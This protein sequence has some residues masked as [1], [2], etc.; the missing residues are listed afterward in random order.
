PRVDRLYPVPRALLLE[1]II[2]GRVLFSGLDLVR[3][4][5]AWATSIKAA[6]SEGKVPNA[7]G[8]G[9]EVLVV[10][11]FLRREHAA[12]PPRHLRARLALEPEQRVPLAVQDHHVCANAVAVALEVSADRP[13]ADVRHELRIVA[14][15]D[16]H[17]RAAL[18]AL[19]LLIELEGPDVGDVVRLPLD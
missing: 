10:F 5:P 6:K 1:L 19:G 4:S 2:D 15:V 7:G 8:T 16:V 12:V 18:A 11:P 14:Q 9:I 3:E 17:V 13:F